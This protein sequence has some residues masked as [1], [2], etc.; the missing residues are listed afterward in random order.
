[1]KIVFM[2]TP[3]FSVPCLRALIDSKHE[4]VGVI[5][6]PD[7]PVGRKQILTPPPVKTEALAHDLRVLQPATLRNGAGRAILEELQPDLVIVVAYG[8]ILPPDFLAYP[9]YGCVNVHASLLPRYRGASPIH[10]A[11]LN[12]DSE[13]GVTTMQMDEGMDT[14]DILLVKKV[15]IGPDD[16]AEALFETL[17]GVGAEAMLETIEAVEAGTLHPVKQDN[18]QAVNVGL[19]TKQLGEIDWSKPALQIHNQIRGLYSWP[20]AYTYWNGT[21]LKIHKAR[22]SEQSTSKAPGTVVQTKGGLLIACGDGGCLELLE[23]QLAGKKR[24]D[25][26]AFLNGSGLVKDMI[27]ESPK[28]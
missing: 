28:Q 21:V 22:L 18:S 10:W 14:G 5:C 20:G 12:G 27:F 17:S 1:M 3:D 4:V 11:I 16:T 26:A 9:K 19:L 24:M 6:Q 8:K 25:A 23:V 7:K 15:P 13:T 2:G